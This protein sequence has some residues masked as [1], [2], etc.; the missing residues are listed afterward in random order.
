MR[1]DS[2][3]EFPFQCLYHTYYRVHG[4]EALN[5]DTCYVNGLEGYEITDKVTQPSPVVA[6]GSEP[7]TLAGEVD[8]VYAPPVSKKQCEV[9][10]GVGQGKTV[11]VTASGVVDGT[12]VPVSC[13]VWNPHA[14]KAAA[15][16]DFDNDGYHHMI[17]VE[18]GL[19]SDNLVLSAGKEAVFTQVIRV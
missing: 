4:G 8:R 7:I 14:A 6:A 2:E 1:N 10:I 12:P 15:M 16:S 9:T 18:P 5:P 13:V 3:F 11:S 19:L 17:C